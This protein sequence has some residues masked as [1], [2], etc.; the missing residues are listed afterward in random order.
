MQ[1]ELEQ[2][3]V[4]EVQTAMVHMCV[5]I[6]IIVIVCWH[7]HVWGCVHMCVHVYTC[8]YNYVFFVMS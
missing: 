1:P 5:C 7:V 3:T 6:I 8:M 2:P 4:H